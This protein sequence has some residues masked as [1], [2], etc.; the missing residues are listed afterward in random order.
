MYPGYSPA[1]HQ[2][3]EAAQEF[4]SQWSAAKAQG[5]EF[6][7]T[8][9]GPQYEFSQAKGLKRA[10]LAKIKAA[11]VARGEGSGSGSGSGSDTAAVRVNTNGASATERTEDVKSEEDTKS[12]TNPYFVIDTNPTPVNLSSN[13]HHPSKRPA[14]TQLLSELVGTK[15]KKS[16]TKH[17]RILPNVTD[18][19]VEFED[20]TGEVDARMKEKE[21]RRKRKD[22]K[23]RKRDSEGSV[24][25]ESASEN[26]IETKKPKKK[27]SKAEA[28]T[29]VNGTVSVKRAGSDGA[30]AE[31]DESTKKRKKS[32]KSNE[33]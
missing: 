12:D 9:N 16:K 32:K 24:V 5:I 23:K 3:G 28:E 2:Y 22:E 29:E 20:I 26:V 10:P 21:E 25:P 4:G 30:E 18:K 13:S 8:P 31:G 14:D 6:Q 19:R 11:N 27:K 17:D 7:P 15:S 1:D 33:N